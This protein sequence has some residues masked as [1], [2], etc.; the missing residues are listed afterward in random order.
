MKGVSEAQR[1]FLFTLGAWISAVQLE[2]QPQAGTYVTS[3]LLWDKGGG[4]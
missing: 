3:K 1:A 2:G 4:G